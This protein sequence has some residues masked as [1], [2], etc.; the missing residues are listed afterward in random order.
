[1]SRKKAYSIDFH[2]MES[3]IWFGIPLRDDCFRLGVA[4]S[5]K[6]LKLYAPFDKADILICSPL[7]LRMVI[8]EWGCEKIIGNERIGEVGP[9]RF[10]LWGR[11]EKLLACGIL[12]CFCYSKLSQLLLH[13]FLMNRLDRNKNHNHSSVQIFLQFWL[14]DISKYF[15][16]LPFK[17]SSERTIE[18]NLNPFQ[19]VILV[20]SRTFSRQCNWLLSM[21]RIFFCNRIGNISLSSSIQCTHNQARLS[22]MCPGY[23]RSYLLIDC[24]RGWSGIRK[25]YIIECSLQVRTQYLDGHAA[26]LCQTLLFSSHRHELFTALSMGRRNHRGFVS[27]RPSSEGLLTQVRKGRKTIGIPWVYL[28]KPDRLWASDFRL[29]FVSVKNCTRSNV[30]TR[31]HNRMRDSTS[32]RRRLVGNSIT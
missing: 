29:N 25:I 3:Q 31:R 15:L 5:N 22:P 2:L 10:Q 1:M 14:F 20:V 17:K 28:G 16:V 23:G 12:F 6:S 8:G 27:F 9:L 30:K 4:L 19:V 21:R 26:S 13:E 11:V 32:L 7:G 24:L 18:A